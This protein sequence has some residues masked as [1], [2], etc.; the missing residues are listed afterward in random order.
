MP[1]DTP[2]IP[3][4]YIRGVNVIDIGEMRISRGYTRRS[5][6]CCLHHDIAYDQAERRIWCRD[7]EKGIDPFDFLQTLIEAHNR[8]LNRLK[9]R[10]RAVTEAES[11]SARMRAT[12]AMD[13]VWRKRTRVPICP[14]CHHG[15][16][17]EDVANGVGQMDKEL[18]AR[19]NANGRNK[20]GSR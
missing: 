9:E 6:M 16:H 19:I 15:I 4:D 7:C 12:R 1:D 3:G 17:P 13:A 10:E 5:P 14:H 18:S 20:G 8:T 2:I 11:F